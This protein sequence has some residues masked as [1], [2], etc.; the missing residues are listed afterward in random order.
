MVNKTTIGKALAG[1]PWWNGQ[2][3]AC[4]NR[5]IVQ[6]YSSAKLFFMVIGL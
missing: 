4:Y 6:N 2:G 3:E 5:V 1:L